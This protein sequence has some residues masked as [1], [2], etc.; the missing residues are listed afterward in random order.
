MYQ[1]GLSSESSGRKLVTLDMVSRLMEQILQ[2]H[3]PRE[4]GAD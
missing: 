4:L 1:N 3:L 2:I